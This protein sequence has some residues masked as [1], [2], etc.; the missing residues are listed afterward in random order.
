MGKKLHTPELLTC[1]FTR[2]DKK[3]EI[4]ISR[5][6]DCDFY[7]GFDLLL[8]VINCRD[9]CNEQ[10]PFVDRLMLV[11]TRCY[12]ICC[13]SKASA[14]FRE[15]DLEIDRRDSLLVFYNLH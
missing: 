1:Q 15:A 3:D 11:G 4:E 6:Q 2:N 13:K 8:P 5:S 10:S 9:F 12:C 7:F 14:R